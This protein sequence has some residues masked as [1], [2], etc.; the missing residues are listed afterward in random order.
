MKLNSFKTID[1]KGLTALLIFIIISIMACKN[2]RQKFHDDPLAI[3]MKLERINSNQ[4]HNL[5]LSFIKDRLN[6]LDCKKIKFDIKIFP[7]GHYPYL[8]FQIQQDSLSSSIR[9]HLSHLKKG[10]IF[11]VESVKCEVESGLAFTLRPI[12][13]EVF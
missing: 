8:G 3:T 12:A 13:I 10:D 1:K 9:N 5:N 7:G 2:D 6:A 11:I 4:L